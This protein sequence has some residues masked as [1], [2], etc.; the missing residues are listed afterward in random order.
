MF[1]QVFGRSQGQSEFTRERA[2]G[3][4]NSLLN[5]SYAVMFSTILQKLF[6]MGLDPTFSI[7][8]VAR[9]AVGPTAVRLSIL[10]RSKC[11]PNFA[12]G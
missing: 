11:P 4:L 1:W 3:G 7:S 5:Y 9:G 8:H 12:N 2:F 10:N 6:G